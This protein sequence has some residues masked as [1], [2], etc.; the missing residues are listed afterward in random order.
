MID[1]LYAASFSSEKLSPTMVLHAQDAASALQDAN[2]PLLH[3]V[4]SESSWNED[5]LKVM[6]PQLEAPGYLEIP[7]VEAARRG[8]RSEGFVTASQQ[9]ILETFD[10]HAYV[11]IGGIKRKLNRRGRLGLIEWIEQRA[12]AH[13]SKKFAYSTRMLRD[14]ISL[15]ASSQWFPK[16]MDGEYELSV[17]LRGRVES[18]DIF[19]EYQGWTDNFAA[20]AEG[21][22]TGKW[23]APFGRVAR[24]AE[25]R[26]AF[27]SL[28]NEDEAPQ[29]IGNSRRKE[30]ADAELLIAGLLAIYEREQSK[31][32]DPYRA[33]LIDQ[34]NHAGTVEQIASAPLSFP[35]DFR[36]NDALQTQWEKE[37]LEALEVEVG[38]FRSEAQI[39][40]ETQGDREFLEHVRKT[41]QWGWETPYPDIYEQWEEAIHR[42][43]AAQF[44]REAKGRPHGPSGL[45]GDSEEMALALIDTSLPQA[46]HQ[47]LLAKCLATWES[48]NT[49][50]EQLRVQAAGYL[51]QN[52]LAE[53][54]RFEATVRENGWKNP[55]SDLLDRYVTERSGQ[56]LDAWRDK[57]WAAYG[58]NG[59]LAASA[60][61]M[62]LQ[63]REFAVDPELKRSIRERLEGIRVEIEA[64][65]K[66]LRAAADGHLSKKEETQFWDAVHKAVSP[67]PFVAAI[68]RWYRARLVA[69][70]D[71]QGR[72]TAGDE[73][74]QARVAAAHGLTEAER[75]VLAE[76]AK[77]Q[78]SEVLSWAEDQIE[79]GARLAEKRDA[80]ALAEMEAEMRRAGWQHF[81][82]PE[83]AEEVQESTPPAINDD[84]RE[85]APRDEADSARNRSDADASEDPS[86]QPEED[87]FETD[88]EPMVFCPPREGEEPIAQGYFTDLY[89][90]DEQTFIVRYRP[91]ETE[92]SKRDARETQDK[93]FYDAHN[94][95]ED[96]HERLCGLYANDSEV[97]VSEFLAGKKC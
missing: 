2:G 82:V 31:F 75:A 40:R 85:G 61:N 20:Q 8:L 87:I 16:L 89:R 66:R 76:R 72:F 79:R 5:K 58:T 45:L 25:V 12:L 91:V 35:K 6:F 41:K 4:T 19:R 50:V 81:V 33:D 71:A 15:V 69:E 24:E 49:A 34:L 95:F 48:L 13:F 11:Y 43:V 67:W 22:L 55:L 62:S 26:R 7:F 42:K 44:L 28:A 57:V 70:L 68:A 73:A 30:S 17:N 37:A 18:F 63:L 92:D 39:I 94:E 59:E 21:I 80:E 65:V 46:L 60:L 78:E 86:P 64:Q 96:E 29:V 9:P 77:D 36:S 97:S 32:S 51:A 10:R 74:V 23:A 84:P 54:K 93:E 53:Y 3:C 83:I 38:L 27:R 14:E 52:D 90:E 1:R 88:D 56:V 47:D